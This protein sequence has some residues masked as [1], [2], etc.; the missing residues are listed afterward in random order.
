MRADGSVKDAA[1][2]LLAPRDVVAVEDEQ[3]VTRLAERGREEHKRREA[4]SMR[5]DKVK[6]DHTHK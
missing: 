4:L 6:S 2:L 5:C 3:L 1:Q